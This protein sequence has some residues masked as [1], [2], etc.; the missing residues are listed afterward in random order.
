MKYKQYANTECRGC[1]DENIYA[2]GLCFSCYRKALRNNTENVFQLKT[3]KLLQASQTIQMYSD[4]VFMAINGN[5]YQTIGDKYGVSRQ[6]IE[7]I[8]HQLATNKRVA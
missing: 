8:L 5:S 7:Q 1:G 4:I 6:R 2:K 3:S